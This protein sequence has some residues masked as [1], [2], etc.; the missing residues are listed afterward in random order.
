MSEALERFEAEW[1][2]RLNT[3]ART[4][5]HHGLTP[6]DAGLH[7]A[8]ADTFV[9]AL[10]FTPIGFNWELLD[11]HG[12]ANSPRSAV[13]ELTKAIA[14]DIS[15]PSKEWLGSTAASRC[16]QDLLAAFDRTS[17]TVVSNRYDGLWNPISRTSVEWGFV[18]FDD[19]Q[20]ALILIAEQGTEQG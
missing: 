1:L 15:N 3:G 7:S 18:C 9:S 19:R 16:A 12:D 8:V 4:S 5:F 6:P 13:G 17:L 20:I 10:G 14:N 2:P 11:A